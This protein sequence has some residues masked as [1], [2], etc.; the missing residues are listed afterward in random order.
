MLVLSCKTS[1]V[2]AGVAGAGR[3]VWRECSRLC[4]DVW[5][6]RL[7]AGAS[8]RRFDLSKPIGHLG[9]GLWVDSGLFQQG[10]GFCL[11]SVFFWVWS[12]GRKGPEV[13]PKEQSLPACFPKRWHLESEANDDGCHSPIFPPFHSFYDVHDRVN[14][15]P[16]KSRMVLSLTL[17]S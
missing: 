11:L 15:Q 14:G 8:T 2:R 1:Q 4:K 7:I 17:V 9:V 13:L 16:R 6:L 12:S 5:G 10:R 3:K